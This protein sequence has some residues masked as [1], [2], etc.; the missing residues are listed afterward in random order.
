MDGVSDISGSLAGGDLLVEI[1]GP[2][3][4]ITLNRPG[5]RNAM[6]EAM[7][8]ALPE[9]MDKLANDTRIRSIVLTG[10]NGHFCAGADVSEFPRTF[11]NLNATRTYNDL[12]EAGRDALTRQPKPTIAV[13]RGL[14]VGGGCGLAVACDLRFAASDARFAMPPA[15][16]GAAY[17]FTGVR[18]LVDLI[19][20]ASTRDMLYSARMVDAEEALRIGLVDRVFTEESVLQEALGY[21]DRNAA[22]SSTSQQTGKMMVQAVLDGAETETKDLRALF[23]DSFASDDF[24]EG[25]Q[26]FL[27]KRKPDFG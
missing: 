21:C 1:A 6:T 24:L 10:A 2:T 14:A 19:G 12:V 15:R 7:W 4:M 25:Y 3:A 18:Q 27:E 8:S 9:L 5:T 20:P 16:L 11:A 22:L 17:R 23:E 13:V 26:A